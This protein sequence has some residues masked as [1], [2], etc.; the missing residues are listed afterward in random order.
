MDT[1]IMTTG[2]STEASGII[3]RANVAAAHLRKEILSGR[4]TVGER[5]SNERLLADKFDVNRGTIRKALKT[6]EQERLITR[7][8]GHGTF[9]TNPVHSRTEASGTAL[10]GA[11]V[12]G[13][14]GIPTEE[15]FFGSILERASVLAASRGYILTTGS[16][17]TE[18]SET[19]HIEALIKNKVK[20][21]IFAPRVEFSKK[22]YDRL[23]REKIPV[24]LLD[25][26]LSG[27]EEDFVGID[28]F[29]GTEMATRHL[30][31]LGHTRIGY[32]GHD[33]PE[34]VRGQWERRMGFSA[35]CMQSK[36]EVRD[37]W[38]VEIK[39]PFLQANL[40]THV[41]MVFSK[42]RK[43]LMQQPRPT[44]I[45]THNDLWAIRVVQV[46]R[47]L[48]IKVPEELSVVGFDHSSMGQRYDVPLTTIDPKPQEVGEAVVDLLMD[49]IER[50]GTR[51]KR[52]I[53]INPQ[54]IIRASTAKPSSAI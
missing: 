14:S 46:A 51:A 23:I 15:Y 50:S 41:E 47:E 38:M 1:D 17:S 24:V 39:V 44:A 25:T 37:T 43:V 30:I 53:F 29:M 9:V 45:V 32:V 20:G 16:N 2:V 6:L 52:S 28:D 4:Y 36:V 27:R 13:S 11:L 40:G 42:L 31:E 7:R 18:D 19:C 54:L 48:Q 35:T 26:R 21:V 5:L 8:H 3:T 34:I 49:K 33:Q 10:M 22:S 12:Y